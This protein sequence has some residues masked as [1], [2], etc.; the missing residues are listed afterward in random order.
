MELALPFAAEDELN[1]PPR[2]ED[3][4]DDVLAC[5]WI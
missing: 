2:G 5:A 4:F 1:E 3:E